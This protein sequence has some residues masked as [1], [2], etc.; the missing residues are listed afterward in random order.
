MLVKIARIAQGTTVRWKRKKK[1]ATMTKILTMA[2]FL[3]NNAHC[4]Q[5]S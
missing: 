2:I 3:R 1:E 5:H 4:A